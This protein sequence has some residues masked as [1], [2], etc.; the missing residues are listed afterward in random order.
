M[1]TVEPIRESET[2]A[3]RPNATPEEINAAS[4]YEEKFV[5]ALF[6]YWSPIVIDAA[7][8]RLG[9]RV[10]DIACGTGVVTRDIAAIVGSEA[11]PVGYDLSPGMLEVAHRIAPWIDWQH[12][13]ADQLPFADNSFDRVVCQYGLM[14]FPDPVKSLREMLRVLKPGGRLAVAVWDSLE[15]NTGFADKVAILERIAGTAAADALRAPFRLGD[16]ATLQIFARDAGIRD[17]ELQTHRGEARFPKLQTF[18]DAEVR[19][20]LPV[21]DVHLDE[22]TIAAIH[23]ECEL[24][25]A[26]YVGTDGNA[27]VMPTSAHIFS[28]TV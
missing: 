5:P 20:W 17:F 22:D 15:S 2:I 27:F 23:A 13:N 21:M 16:I 28:A 6:K 10:L 14:F 11:V 9:Q 4:F 8:I 26:G 12:G 7:D 3:S 25:L 24:L 19:G 18:V 1:N